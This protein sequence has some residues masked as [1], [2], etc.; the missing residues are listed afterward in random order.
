MGVQVLLHAEPGVLLRAE[1]EVLLLLLL[2]ADPGVQE[3][4]LL[5]LTLVLGVRRSRLGEGVLSRSVKFSLLSSLLRSL[6]E[7]LEYSTPGGGVLSSRGPSVELSSVLKNMPGPTI[8][9]LLVVEDRTGVLRG[10]T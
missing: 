9:V 6:L 3:L 8:G 1:P 7:V 2:H 5:V 4:V 10:V